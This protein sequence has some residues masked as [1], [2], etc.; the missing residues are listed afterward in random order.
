MFFF[1]SG[2]ILNK[3]VWG[4]ALTMKSSPGRG[5][6]E[7]RVVLFVYLWARERRADKGRRAERKFQ[8][9][10][11]SCPEPSAPLGS[12]EAIYFVLLTFPSSTNKKPSPAPGCAKQLACPVALPP[13]AERSP[14]ISCRVETLLCCQSHSQLIFASKTWLIARD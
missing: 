5:G 11:P 9:K 4:P 6:G 8:N 3:S 14:L 10:S 13:L 7:K 1:K 2:K 12:N